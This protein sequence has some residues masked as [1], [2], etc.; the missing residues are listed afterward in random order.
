[1]G[2]IMKAECAPIFVEAWAAKLPRKVQQTYPGMN[3]AAVSS[4]LDAPMKT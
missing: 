1:M 4:R 3:A 2:S